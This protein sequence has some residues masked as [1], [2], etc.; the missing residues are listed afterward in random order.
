MTLPEYYRRSLLIPPVVLVL[1]LSLSSIAPPWIGG[2]AFFGLA[3]GGI[4]YWILCSWLFRQSRQR[5][6]AWLRRNLALAPLYLLPL[7][8]VWTFLAVLLLEFTTSDRGSIMDPI[9]T[10]GQFV[11]VASPYT[12]FVGYAFVV[13]AFGLRS[14]LQLFGKIDRA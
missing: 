4:P 3:L 8:A 14:L 6:V 11:L 2:V 12:L 10:A 13:L 1:G 5:P 7:V 9:A